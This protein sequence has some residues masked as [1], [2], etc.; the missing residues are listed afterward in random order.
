MIF[1]YD[2][3]ISGWLNQWNPLGQI[4]R[5]SCRS[6]ALG[7]PGGGPVGHRWSI[8]WP[9]ALRSLGLKAATVCPLLGYF[10]T[11]RKGLFQFQTTVSQGEGRGGRDC[12]SIVCLSDVCQGN[13]AEQD[14]YNEGPR[15]CFG[16][17]VRTG[18]ATV[19]GIVWVSLFNFCGSQKCEWFMLWIS[20]SN[21]HQKHLWPVHYSLWVFGRVLECVSSISWF[22]W[23]SDHTNAGHFQYLKTAT[24]VTW[25]GFGR[26]PVLVMPL[27]M[28]FPADRFCG[29]PHLVSALCVTS[30]GRRW[31]VKSGETAGSR[32]KGRCLS[33]QTWWFMPFF[34]GVRASR[35]VLS[36]L[37]MASGVFSEQVIW[38]VQRDFCLKGAFEGRR[39]TPCSMRTS[40]DKAMKPK[41]WSSSTAGLNPGARGQWF[42]GHSLR[43]WH[44]P[45]LRAVGRCWKLI[46]VYLSCKLQCI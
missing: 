6:S 40:G 45:K 7:A 8:L 5:P 15:A 27:I 20:L 35:V 28:S 42:Q 23:P 10:F 11:G 12:S 31:D 24:T 22:F 37:V 14:D 25:V 19:L 26:N 34:P 44:V 29:D 38:V 17:V 30:Q 2:S 18:W 4:I 21:F 13:P 39:F 33:Q 43:W 41:S 36:R 46:W 32:F 1:Q 9:G 3:N 16:F